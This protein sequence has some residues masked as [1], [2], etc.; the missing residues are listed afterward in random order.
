LSD[1]LLPVHGFVLA[2]GKSSRMGVDKA[3]MPFC[4]R[5]MVEIA[6]EKLRSFCAE[7][8]IAG[9]R[10]DLSGLAPVVRETHLEAG[11]T[12]GVEAGLNA[13]SEAWVLFLPVDVPLVPRELVR[14]WASA[15][16]QRHRDGCWA[17][18][19]VSYGERQPT[20]CMLRR[21]CL[22]L[23]QA[24]M[25]GGERRLARLLMSLD[26]S[27]ENW[28][29][30]CAAEELMPESETERWFCNVNTRLEFAEAEAWSVHNEAMPHT[31]SG[32]E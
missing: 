2:G 16:L 1:I 26:R 25:A 30:A 20:F 19:L 21:E 3:M 9:N 4:G 22:K 17:S 24:E 12:A 11:P 6:L 13:A 5:P 28:L 31:G 23:V 18:Y 29:W 8:S 15:T 7:V 14:A 10:D 32:Y 27:K